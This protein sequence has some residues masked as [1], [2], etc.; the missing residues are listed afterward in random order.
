[1][2]GEI[3]ALGKTPIE[4]IY[5]PNS[6]TTAQA[7][8]KL[9]TTEFNSEPCEVR[10]VGSAKPGKMSVNQEDA[11]YYYDDQREEPDEMSEYKRETSKTKTK[12]LLSNKPSKYAKR[13]TSGVKLKQIDKTKLSTFRNDGEGTARKSDHPDTARKSEFKETLD[14]GFLTLK[15]KL[16]ADEQEFIS[17]YRQLEELDKVKE[18]KF[19]ECL[20]DPPITSEDIEFYKE[21]RQNFIDDTNMQR[22]KNTKYITEADTDRVIVDTNL[23][24]ELKPQLDLYQNNHFELRK[25]C[26]NLMLKYIN[27][28]VIR[29]RAGKRLMQIKN[30]LKEQHM[31]V[32]E[33][34]KHI[35]FND[36]KFSSDIEHPK[37]P[38]E[39]GLTSIKEKVEG[40]MPTNF[41]DMLPF[42]P[43]ED[44]DFEIYNYKPFEVPKM[45][46]YIPV[47]DE[48]PKRQGCEHE[49]AI[50]GPRG[51]PAS[52]IRPHKE[53]IL[54]LPES[55]KKPFDMP[56]T[57]LIM[58]HPTLRAYVPLKKFTEIDPEFYLQP[59]PIPRV[60]PD[61]DLS[62]RADRTLDYAS[63][64]LRKND[65]N[66]MNTDIPGY[67]GINTIEK[68]PLDF[69][70]PKEYKRCTIKEGMTCDRTLER[71]P[72]KLPAADEVDYPSDEDSGN[73]NELEDEVIQQLDMEEGLEEKDSEFLDKND[74]II[75]MS[76]NI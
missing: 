28:M 26:L 32:N 63:R 17:K 50:R 7:T 27:Q 58:P 75:S 64:F 49:Y 9:T 59:H 37:M 60:V 8:F 12:T 70:E 18:I 13:P 41:D 65:A 51:D 39:A 68:I 47:L 43:I 29:Q 48:K 2:S 38:V 53:K 40:E 66:L 16:T 62:I 3:K 42:K 21:K 76:Y 71:K 24:M 52:F 20:G 46:H 6:N 72:V 1:M 74:G 34:D 23:P 55:I 35:V 45:S 11:P 25:R 56:R 67:V 33:E 10:V 15:T 30:K 5:R 4:I 73:E 57:Y 31:N 61:D 36:W 19:F 14:E 22:F 69:F 44:L 54:S